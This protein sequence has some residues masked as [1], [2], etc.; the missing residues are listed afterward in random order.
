[1]NISEQVKE[2]V[3]EHLRGK[4]NLVLLNTSWDTF[5]VVF[6]LSLI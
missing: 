5:N 6:F 2:V 3:L 4:T 1:M